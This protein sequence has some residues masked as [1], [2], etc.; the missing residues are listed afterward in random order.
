MHKH[1]SA[2]I[3]AADIQM[4]MNYSVEMPDQKFN[5][6]MKYYAVLNDLIYY[7]RD[8]VTF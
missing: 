1:L 3:L 7:K 2:T 6:L 8:H 5:W 4:Q